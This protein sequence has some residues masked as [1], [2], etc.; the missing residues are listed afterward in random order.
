MGSTL[1]FSHLV[2]DHVDQDIGPGSS[3]AIA[4]RGGRGQEIKRHDEGGR[5]EREREEKIMNVTEV[6]ITAEAFL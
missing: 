6:L 5:R 4:A 3:S 1:T 2:E